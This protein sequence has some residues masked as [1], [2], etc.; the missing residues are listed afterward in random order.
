MR[1]GPRS[2][3]SRQVRGPRL[4]ARRPAAHHPARHR[5]RGRR[6]EAGSSRCGEANPTVSRRSSS[7]TSDCT[8]SHRSATAASESARQVAATVPAVHRTAA[9][10]AAGSSSSVQ[11]RPEVSRDQATA[12]PGDGRPSQ[13]RRTGGTTDAARRARRASPESSNTADTDRAGPTLSLA[14]RQAAAGGVGAGIGGWGADP[15]PAMATP[16]ATPPANSS[17]RPGIPAVQGSETTNGLPPSRALRLAAAVCAASRVR[18]LA[19]ADLVEP[20]VLHGHHGHTQRARFLGSIVGALAAGDRGDLHAVDGTGRRCRGCGGRGWCRAGGVGRRR[21]RDLGGR[22]GPSA[23]GC[24]PRASRI[25]LQVAALVEEAE[26]VLELDI[27]PGLGHAI[28]E[29]AAGGGRVCSR[30]S[31]CARPSTRPEA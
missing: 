6:T 7:G 25:P 22:V 14:S 24:R 18:I 8:P 12:R 23:V 31:R 13:S 10:A 5:G 20:L 2:T 11:N 27:V 26:L 9:P 28:G 3:A 4:S 19:H 29:P 1:S 16:M 21:S 17:A 15:H 30:R